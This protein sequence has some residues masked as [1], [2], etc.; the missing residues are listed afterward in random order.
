MRNKLC[1]L[2][3]MLAWFVVQGSYAQIQRKNLTPEQQEKWDISVEINRRLAYRENPPAL[4]K[5]PT[6]EVSGIKGK[7]VEVFRAPENAPQPEKELAARK[8]IKEYI[9]K[10]PELAESLSKDLPPA[11]GMV[12]AMEAQGVNTI[13]EVSLDKL[14]EKQ[15]T[16]LIES[17]DAL[18]KEWKRYEPKLPY[19]TKEEQADLRKQLLEQYQKKQTE[20]K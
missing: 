12:A 5:T 7:N 13:A 20:I 1:M 8:R 18:Q 3:S 14:S 2:L 16:Q 9:K 4:V 15:A 6:T 19:M 10:H 17:E 11:K